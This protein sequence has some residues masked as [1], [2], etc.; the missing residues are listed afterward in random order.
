MIKCCIDF[1]KFCKINFG[2]FLL[3]CIRE[4]SKVTL[5]YKVSIA[6]ENKNPVSKTHEEFD[7]NQFEVSTNRVLPKIKNINETTVKT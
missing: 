4:N 2:Y 3:F 1:L 7:S 5:I 6:F